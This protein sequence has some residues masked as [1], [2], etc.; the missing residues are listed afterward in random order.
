MNA[1]KCK[2]LR[3]EIRR[4]ATEAQELV[5]PRQL[6]GKTKHVANRVAVNHPMSAHG[7]Y[8]LLKKEMKTFT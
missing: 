1:K 5:Q 4:M 6:V 2:M 8:K 3:K 7:A